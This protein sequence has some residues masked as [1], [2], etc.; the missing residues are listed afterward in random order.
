MRWGFVNLLIG[1][2]L[3]IGAQQV[4]PLRSP[5]F[6]PRVVALPSFMRS[7]LEKTAHVDLSNVAK[8]EF[9]G[10]KWRDLLCAPAD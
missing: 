8:Q 10:A 2:R 9:G 5:E 6:L 3:G 4:P 1:S 7:S